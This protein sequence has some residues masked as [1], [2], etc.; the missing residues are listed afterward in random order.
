MWLA[1]KD[2]DHYLSTT[3]SHLMDSLHPDVVVLLGDIFSDGFQASASQWMDYL[4]V[5]YCVCYVAVI[6]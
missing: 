4:N 1:R 2:A 5:S 3:F 6:Y